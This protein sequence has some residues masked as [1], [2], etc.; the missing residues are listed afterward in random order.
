MPPELQGCAECCLSKMKVSSLSLIV[1]LWILDIFQ[2]SFV[3]WV[4]S[5]NVIHRSYTA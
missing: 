5:P 4:G 1:S 2:L 3:A